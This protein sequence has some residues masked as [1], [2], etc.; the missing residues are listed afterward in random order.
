MTDLTVFMRDAGL[1]AQRRYAEHLD[2][3][4]RNLID[5]LRISDEEFFEQYYIEEEG[6]TYSPSFF[7]DAADDKVTLKMEFKFRVKRKSDEEWLADCS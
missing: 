7:T 4:L 3:Y 1:D 5:Q 6:P 2:A